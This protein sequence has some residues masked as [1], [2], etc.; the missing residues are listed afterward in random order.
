M[1]KSKTFN[2]KS[3]CF[4]V[5]SPSGAGKTTLVQNVLDMGLQIEKTISHTTRKARPNEVEGKDYYFVSEKDFKEKVSKGEFVEHATVYDKHYGTSQKSIEEIFA[6]GKDAIL[7][8]ENQ[9]A[10]RVAQ[11]F[12]Q[13]VFILIVP[14]S[15]QELEARLTQRE[16]ANSTEIQKRLHLAKKEVSDL[17]WFDYVICNDDLNKATHELKAVIEASRLRI[18]YQEKIL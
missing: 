6:Q 2:R 3:I 13:V 18:E 7:V 9:G 10:K 8:I 16:G 15:W 17:L 4:V 5:S 12:D 1:N 14:P 11:L